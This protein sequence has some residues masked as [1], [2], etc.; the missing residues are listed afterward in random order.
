MRL[1]WTLPLLLLLGWVSLFALSPLAIAPQDALAGLWQPEPGVIGQQLV[2][3]IRLPRLL[4][5]MLVG[6]Q[7]AL[8][9][10]LM[11]GMTRN[12]L[13]SPGLLGVTAG[14][15]LGMALVSTLPQGWLPMPL[16]ATLGGA[17]SWALVMLLGQGWRGAESQ[18]RLVLAG[19]AISALCVAL[20][21]TLVILDEEQASAVLGWLAG[22]LAQIDWP[23]FARLW[24]FALPLLLLTLLLGPT[25]N[26]LA[27]GDE[28]AQS[29]GLSPAISRLVISVLVLLLVGFAVATCGTLGFVGLL[30]PHLSRVL[31]GHDYRRVLPLC[32]V[33]GAVLVTAGDL[34]GRAVVFPTETPAGAVLALIGAPYFIYLVRRQ[35]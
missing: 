27:L 28:G 30:V 33:L 24:P 29:L 20:T 11:Q 26:L 2:H 9:G 16:A 21:R 3:E 25:L 7:L 34:L 22:S 14:A 31:V 5:G 13:A 32:M 17:A 1:L 19:V 18:A 6:A 8:A 15:G 35:P 23:A 10:A 12:P 4:G